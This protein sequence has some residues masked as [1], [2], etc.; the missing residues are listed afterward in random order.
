MGNF[1][2]KLA[3]I[4]IAIFLLINIPIFGIF[5]DNVKNDFS[6][7][8]DN[9]TEEYE[10]V[11]DKVN[12]VK[13]KVVETKETVEG[14]IET[15][16]EVVY[17]VGET[18]DKVNGVF[19]GNNNEKSSGEESFVGTCSNEEKT[20]EICTMEYAPVCGDDGVTYGNIC[21]ACA[22]KNIDEYTEGECA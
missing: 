10:R 14:A 18:V 2:A 4:I 7:K 12:G 11:K 15:V 5:L 6:E 21:S 22:S 19:G 16:N 1:L 17:T 3:L 13:D 8:R 20:A 9:V